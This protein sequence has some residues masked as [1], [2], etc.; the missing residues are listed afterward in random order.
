M[1]LSV[2]VDYQEIFEMKQATEVN[3]YLILD[4]LVGE[5]I[6]P[7]VVTLRSNSDHQDNILKV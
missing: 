4:P 3:Q 7:L 2:Q 5:G 6:L 1:C